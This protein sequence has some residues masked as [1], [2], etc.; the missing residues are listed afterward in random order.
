M[1]TASY[2]LFTPLALGEGLTLKNRVILSPL[3]RARCDPVTRK[4]DDLTATYYA[5]R[6]GAGLIISEGCAMSEQ[7][8]GWYATPA[9][10]NREQMEAWKKVV[11]AVHSKDGKIF[12]QMVH[13][14]RQGHSSFNSKNELVSPS[15]IPAINGRI[16]NAQGE[17]SPH[18]VPR[19]L[20]TDEIAGIVEDYRK[21]AALAKEAGFD[22]IEVHASGIALLN[23]FLQSVTNKRNDKY[24]GS[25]ENRAR[26]LFEVLEAVQTV[27]PADRIGVRVS[28]NHSYS[29]MGSEDNDEMFTYVMEELGKLKLSYL[30]ILD[31]LATGYEDKYHG[32]CRVL[33]ILDAKN[34]FK[35]PVFATASYTR[36]IAEGAI[37]SG[38]ADA[39][40]FGLLY[41]ANPDLAE[42]FEN[43]WPLAP[44]A[45]YDVWYN[46][47]KGAEGY[48][49]FPPYKTSEE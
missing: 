26:F 20:E 44:H 22:G 10:Y 15:G 11:D 46:P 31:G 6:V 4:A 9:L 42:R 24:G 49:T 34:A 17:H 40:G 45:E 33:T 28:P 12:L 21:S 5:Q 3:T 8:Y 29:D 14:G 25:F 19:A 48:T 32:K 27:W 47:A 23:E 13:W 36:D 18:E 43:D 35:G 39:V 2:K 37:R 41:I 38:A 16:R 30:A 1:T 7:G